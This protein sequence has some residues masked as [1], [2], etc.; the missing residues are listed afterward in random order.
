M[1]YYELHK[2]ELNNVRLVAMDGVKAGI[3][4]RYALELFQE[5][6]VIPE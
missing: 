3:V 4:S 6:G 1:S 2:S 5:L